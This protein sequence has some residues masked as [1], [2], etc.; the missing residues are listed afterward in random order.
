MIKK[1][2]MIGLKVLAKKSII[3]TELKEPLESSNFIGF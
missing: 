1:V 3:K 2:T